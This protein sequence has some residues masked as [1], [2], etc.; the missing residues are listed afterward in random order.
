MSNSGRTRHDTPRLSSP[1]PF[2][3]PPSLLLPSTISFLEAGLT[4]RI[5]KCRFLNKSITYLG[6]NL[7]QN[8]VHTTP[9]KTKS[10]QNFPTPG[11]VKSV[12]SFLGLSGFYRS[13]IQ[14][15]SSIARPLTQLLRK[16]ATFEWGPNQQR[17]FDELKNALTSPPVLAYPDFD[18]PFY[19]YTDASG[20][21]L[22]AALMQYDERNKLQPLAYASR[23]VNKA[24][25]NYST[26]HLE[27]LAVVWAL[28]HFRDIIYG[29]D[30]HVRTDHAS[31]VELF[32][33]KSLT[34]KLAR[35]SLIVQ[36][37]QPS[38]A[39]VPGAVNHVADA[40]SRYIGAIDT[41]DWDPY[42]DPSKSHDSNLNDSIRSAQRSDTFCQPLLYYLE[43]GDPNTL[44]HLPVPLPEFDLQ[45]NILVRK[46][47]ITSK[48]GPNRDVTQIVI[49]ET[50]VPVILH[51]IHSSPHA[52]HPGKN[53]TLLQARLLYYW[54]KMRLDIIKYIDNCNSCAENHGSVAKPVPIR[55]YPI[56]SQPWDTLAI[57]L[58]QLPL[59]TE[60]HKYLL[61]TIDHFSRFTI[62]S[63]LK[64]KQAT[65][66]ARAL[67]DDVFCKYNTPKVLL[68]DN[69]TEFNNQILDAIC[70]DYGI[71]KANVLPYKP[72]SNGLVERSNRKILS[73][74]RTLV[75][76][77][78]SSLTYGTSTLTAYLGTRYRG[79]THQI[80]VWPRCI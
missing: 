11:D 66:V 39:H 25:S 79:P 27:A 23:T 10:I 2:L 8:G 41:T 16:D 1:P 68:S 21:G 37:F 12:R 7:D 15:Y 51:Q 6:H 60:G 13:F 18:K 48:Q 26:T 45:D 52:G 61:V 33:T 75:G 30:I 49:P 28:R 3:C 38:F 32:K 9:D 36:D 56:P 53:R 80:Q 55:N 62:L 73:C 43:S 46:T 17:A 24:E 40:L 58:L 54:P 70:R 63:P 74:L 5:D 42:E 76:D 31:V 72:N 20:K 29:Y 77:I 4:V 14:N 64:D 35:W 67:I 47:Y 69:G 50:L 57:D 19:L 78:S 59:T 65:T 44:P 71:T 34:G 22:G